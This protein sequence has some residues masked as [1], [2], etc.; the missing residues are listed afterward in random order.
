MRRS[1][2]STIVWY[3]FDDGWAAAGAFLK[4]KSDF[5]ASSQVRGA[6]A[7]DEII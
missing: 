7:G 5:E 4:R 6:I 1:L 2:Q 3:F